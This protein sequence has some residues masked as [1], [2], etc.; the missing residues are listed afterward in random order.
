MKAETFFSKADNERIFAAIREVES[1]TAG[2]IAVMVIDR[3]DTYPEARIMIGILFGGLL[4]LIVS[5]LLFDD[6][7]WVF[8]P[9]TAL[10]T[11]LLG[12]FSQFTPEFLRF[13][14]PASR[15]ESKVEERAVRAFYE[16]GL[17]KTRDDTGVLFFISLFEHK[18]WVLADAG[19][20]R[21]MTQV[22]LQRYAGD[23]ARSIKDGTASEALCR[24]IRSVGKV[25]A[26]HFPI[27]PDDV[28][29][30]SDQVIIG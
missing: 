4:S 1:K 17:Y 19:I 6:S 24:E 18:V 5:D 12:W 2:E 3:S 8:A 9:V 16:K 22:D 13:F 7:L 14:V 30:L 26:E 11:V 10:L 20:Y 15:L 21:K 28:N 27:K 23:I 25:L 29:E